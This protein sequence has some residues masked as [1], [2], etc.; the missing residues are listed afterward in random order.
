MAKIKNTQGTFWTKSKRWLTG[1]SGT[2]AIV[3]IILTQFL[4]FWNDRVVNENNF[5]QAS[6]VKEM[7]NNEVVEYLRKEL[8]EAKLEITTLLII[9]NKS[10]KSMEDSII[11]ISVRP[12]PTGRN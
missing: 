5:P 4:D 11:E 7:S 10:D 9:L 3:I 1:L 2:L 6:Q 12:E 8:L